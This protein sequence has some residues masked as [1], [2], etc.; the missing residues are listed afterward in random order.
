MSAQGGLPHAGI[1]AAG[2]GSRLAASHPGLLKPLVPVSGVP[3]CHWVARGLRAAGAREVTVLLNSRGRAVRDS[4]SRAF[5]ETRWDFLEADTASSWESFR[6][7]SG[8]L[9][10]KAGG[11]MIS[12]V[13]SLIPPSQT[14]MFAARA[15]HCRAEAA[16][17]LTAFVDD[18]KPLWA[19]VGHDGFVCA[20]GPKAR[21]K[22]RVTS[23]LYYMT[24]RLASRMPEAGAFDSLRGYWT[25]LVEGGARVAGVSL[26][27]TVDVDRPEDIR[28]AEG[29]LK[30]E[31]A[32]W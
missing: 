17:A 14:A 18:E 10:K 11:F 7:V 15:A 4:L 9:S 1:I 20:L 22:D 31:S 19:D 25:G 8:A 21:L 24:D 5:P 13:D 32:S 29:F 3:L 12:T 2:E 27:K 28:E 30:Q 16:L 23:G 6:L 26:T